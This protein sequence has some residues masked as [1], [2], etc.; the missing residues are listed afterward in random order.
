[1]SHTAQPESFLSKD[2]DSRPMDHVDKLTMVYHADAGLVGELRYV[3]N[4]ARGTAHCALCD[5]THATVR[6]KPAWND[7][8]ATLPVDTA[9]IHLNQ[10]TSE[11]A[12]FT[13]DRTPCVIAH[14]RESKGL[15]MVLT[16][17]DL[18]TCGGSVEAFAQRLHERLAAQHLT[19]NES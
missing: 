11:V 4:R 17:E 16:P 15:V 5:I 10:Q 14:L 12:Q 8:L 19:L 3:W 9:V 7:L 18:D 6:A 2:Y 1:M 13:Q